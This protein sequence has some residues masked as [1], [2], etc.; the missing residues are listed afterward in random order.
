MS[1]SPVLV[2]AILTQAK[3]AHYLLVLDTRNTS[4]PDY[5][6]WMVGISTLMVV[7]AFTE[8]EH[9]VE[10]ALYEATTG[11]LVVTA[12]AYVQ[13]TTQY[14]LLSLPFL[15]FLGDRSPATT[16]CSDGQWPIA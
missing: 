6:T 1:E 8:R 2:N 14:W 11:K 4:H 9:A 3:D 16:N 10:G 12:E 7:P 5:W 15:P 13:T